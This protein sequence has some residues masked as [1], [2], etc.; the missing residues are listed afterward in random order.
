MFRY[1]IKVFTDSLKEDWSPEKRK[2]LWNMFIDH[3]I[4]IWKGYVVN[5]RNNNYV[6]ALM[7][8]VFREAFNE[9]HLYKAEHYAY[10]VSFMKHNY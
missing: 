5:G 7:E 2:I 10:W 8:R 9:G 4:K 1:S 3:M 6:Y